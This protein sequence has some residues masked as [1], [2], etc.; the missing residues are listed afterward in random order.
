[1]I[2]VHDRAA[3][4]PIALGGLGPV[5]RVVVVEDAPRV[6]ICRILVPGHQLVEGHGMPPPAADHELVIGEPASIELSG[7]KLTQ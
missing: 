5:G 6:A 4:L 7:E 2:P 1:M 3:A